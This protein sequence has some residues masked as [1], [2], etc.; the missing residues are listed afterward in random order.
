M[1]ECRD[2]GCVSSEGK[3]AFSSRNWENIKE[4]VA[5]LLKFSDI[6]NVKHDICVVR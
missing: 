3:L 4:E 5:I 2:K 6:K 1:R